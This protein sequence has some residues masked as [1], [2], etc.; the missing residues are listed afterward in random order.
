[1]FR[2]ASL[3]I[4]SLAPRNLPLKLHC[5]IIGL[6]HHQI[7]AIISA[8][9]SASVASLINHNLY[10]YTSG[11]FI[12]NKSQRLHECYVEFNPCALL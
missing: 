12:F 2:Q 3:Y 7:Q 5:Q 11:R 6:K 1:M 4:T 10:T 8:N 9:F